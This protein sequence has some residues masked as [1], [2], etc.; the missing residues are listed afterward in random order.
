MG[1][2]IRTV[3]TRVEQKSTANF[4]EELINIVKSK[5]YTQTRL[6]R[7]MLYILLGIT[8]NDIENMEQKTL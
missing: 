3:Q 6:Q 4:G 8:K 7:I 5:R 1:Y 2:K